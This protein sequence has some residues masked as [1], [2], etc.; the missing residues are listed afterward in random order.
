VTEKKKVGTICLLLAISTRAKGEKSARALGSANRQSKP[1]RGLRRR[2][3]RAN[4]RFDG[5]GWKLDAFS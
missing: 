1:W 3:I 5:G 4:L 2:R